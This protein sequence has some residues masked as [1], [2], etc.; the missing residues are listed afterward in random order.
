MKKTIHKLDKQLIWL[1]QQPAKQFVFITFAF[2]CTWCM[3]FF[4]GSETIVSLLEAYSQV[5]TSIYYYPDTDE[6]VAI[7]ERFGEHWVPIFILIT[8]VILAPIME[9]ILFQAAIQSGIRQGFNNPVFT[10]L[11]SGVIFGSTHLGNGLANTINALGLGFGFAVIYEY[12]RIHRGHGRAIW[13]TISIH[14]FWNFLAINDFSQ[15]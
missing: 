5:D 12:F 3:I 9:T 2:M 6:Y 4:Y 14:A 10:I 15:Y 1:Y 7:K 11:V 13:M 8:T